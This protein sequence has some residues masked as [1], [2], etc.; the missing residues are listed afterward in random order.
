MHDLCSILTDFMLFMY[1]IVR[2]NGSYATGSLCKMTH[3]THL[4]ELSDRA[5]SCG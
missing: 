5:W 4:V 3:G 1:G 2:V